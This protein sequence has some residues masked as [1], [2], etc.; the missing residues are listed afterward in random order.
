VNTSYLLDT[1][2]VDDLREIL[3]YTQKQWGGKQSKIYY[4]KLKNCMNTYSNGNGLYKELPELS[5]GL[6]MGLCGHHYIFVK[7]R[8]HAPAAILA[9][10]HQRMDI[11]ERLKE[12][13]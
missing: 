2:A 1:A 11:I 12:R 10:L 4:S 8:Q 3:R 6:R 5:P 7:I 9:I 13:I